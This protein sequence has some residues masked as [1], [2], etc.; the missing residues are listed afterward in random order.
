MVVENVIDGVVIACKVVAVVEIVVAAAVAVVTDFV[1][2]EIEIVEDV[3]T[4]VAVIVGATVLV[5]T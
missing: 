1:F 2:V 4:E 5:K 3:A